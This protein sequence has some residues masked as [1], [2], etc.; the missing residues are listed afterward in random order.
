[1]VTL[2]AFALVYENIRNGE[3]SGAGSLRSRLQLGPRTK[4][5][6]MVAVVAQM[7]AGGFSEKSAA[8]VI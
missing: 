4:V 7:R 3:S 1:M 6:S 8:R 5:T 2:F